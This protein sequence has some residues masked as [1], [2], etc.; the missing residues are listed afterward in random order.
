MLT[1]PPYAPTLLLL[2]ILLLLLLLSLSLS[3]PILLIPLLLF[4]YPLIL[5]VILPSL[6]LASTVSRGI[7]KAADMGAACREIRDEIN[8]CRQTFLAKIKAGKS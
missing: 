1:P 2:S 5:L 8:A 4:F 3:T 6:F 7:S